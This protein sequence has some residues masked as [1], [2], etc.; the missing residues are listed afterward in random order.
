M[1][2]HCGHNQIQHGACFPDTGAFCPFLPEGSFLF[3][4]MPD[5][6]QVLLGACHGDIQQSC[7]FG[8]A[9]SGIPYLE[10]V[11]PEGIPLCMSFP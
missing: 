8:N 2:Q 3:F 11:K 6:D 5:Q 1:A 9:C 7:I 10:C 4:V